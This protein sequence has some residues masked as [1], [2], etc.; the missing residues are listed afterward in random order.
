MIERSRLM[1][2]RPL[3]TFAGTRVLLG[4]IRS[5]LR[6]NVKNRPPSNVL[7]VASTRRTSRFGIVGLGSPGNRWHAWPHALMV[8]SRRSFLY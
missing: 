6:A 5:I 7:D 1:G 3:L 4:R 2:S 8:K